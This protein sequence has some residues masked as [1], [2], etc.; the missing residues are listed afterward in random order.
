MRIDTETQPLEPGKD[1][2]MIRWRLFL[3][4]PES[5][6]AENSER[7]SSRFAAFLSSDGTGRKISGISGLFCFIRFSFVQT[8]KICFIKINLS[9]DCDIQILRKGKRDGSNSHDICRHIISHFAVT[10][11]DSSGKNTILIIKNH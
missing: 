6:I 3:I 8:L 9:P 5:L 10:S 2:K 11:R 4:A 1:M 7:N